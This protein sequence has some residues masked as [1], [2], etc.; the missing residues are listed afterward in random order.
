MLNC[1]NTL[2]KHSVKIYSSIYDK[3]FPVLETGVKLKDLRTPRMSKAMRKSS[4]QK[5]KLYIKFL[6][7]KNPEDEL[8][9]KNYKNLFEKLRK[10]SKQNYY[11]SLL[12]KHKDNAK[13][14]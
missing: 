14:R 11:L 7:S 3:N 1:T 5:Q 4:K 13:N 10:K 6:K 2:Y 8:I 9:Y 12:E